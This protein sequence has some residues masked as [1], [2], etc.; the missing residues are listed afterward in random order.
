MEATFLARV[1]GQ[2]T[3]AS[4][5]LPVAPL[6]PAS[7]VPTPLPLALPQASTA[8]LRFA[9]PSPVPAPLP[10]GAAP[11]RHGG[12]L[13]VLQLLVHGQRMPCARLFVTFK[14]ATC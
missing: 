13:G 7:A 11:S 4:A 3:E 9:P 2:P 14:N 6:L 5:G 1:T 10:L 12:L 8:G